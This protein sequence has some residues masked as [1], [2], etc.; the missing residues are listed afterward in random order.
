MSISTSS[1][2]PSPS[3]P[4]ILSTTDPDDPSFAIWTIDAKVTWG[5][6]ASRFHQQKQRLQDLG[7]Q[8]IGLRLTADAWGFAALAALQALRRDAYL[9]DATLDRDKQVEWAKQLSLDRVVAT[10]GDGNGESQLVATTSTDAGPI[11]APAEEDRGSVTLLTSGTTGMPKAVRHSWLG[12]ARPVRIQA[13]GAS[14]SWLLAFRP[15]LY[16]GL[17]VALQS[18]MNRSCLVVADSSLT[19]K[20]V[21]Q[22]MIKSA[23]QYASATPSYWRRLLMSVPHD[24]LARVPLVQIT[25]GGEVADQPILDQLRQIHPQARIAH[26]YA[27]TEMGRCFSVTDGQ[28]G[29]PAEYLAKPTRDGVQLRIESGQLFVR[30]ANAMLGYDSANDEG[31]RDGCSEIAGSADSDWFPTRDLVEQRGGRVFFVGRNSDMINVGGNKVYPL[32]VE[33]AIRQLPVV[34]DVRIFGVDSS[35]AGQLVACQAVARPGFDNEEVR[36]A[37]LAHCRTTLDRYQ[38]PRVVEMLDH[39][40]LSDAGKIVR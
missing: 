39:L 14:Q 12:L 2:G 32:A 10:T 24:S 13:A 8:R 26:I 35:V 31:N 25:L 6:L 18:L 38:C 21:G 28:A 3:L 20:D 11:A 33:R 1:N 27:T 17:Q 5:N 30:S 7:G 19:P 9:F 15:H 34:G 16:A 36:Q 40:T 4:H 22:L 37:I 29:F 23:V